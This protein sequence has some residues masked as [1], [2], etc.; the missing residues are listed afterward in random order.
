VTDAGIAARLRVRLS[1]GL[2][3]TLVL[4]GLYLALMAPRFLDHGGWAAITLP[5]TA[6]TRVAPM[7]PYDQ[8]MGGVALQKENLPTM[9]GVAMLE[10]GSVPAQFDLARLTY[11]YLASLLAPF[12]GLFHAFEIIN[13]ICWAAASL[14]SWRFARAITGSEAAGTLAAMLTVT[15]MGWAVHVSDYAAHI[16]AQVTYF[17]GMVALYESG[18][19]ERRRRLSVHLAL[20]AYMAIAS[21][22][23]NT[24]IMLAA[25]YAVLAFRRNRWTHMLIA[26]A[27]V[28]T[29]QPIWVR[30]M[31]LLATKS[32]ATWETKLLQTSAGYWVDALVQSPL[33]FAG[34]IAQDLIDF[35]TIDFPLILPLG[36]IGIA[37]APQLKGRRWFLLVATLVPIAAVMPFRMRVVGTIGYSIFGITPILHATI[38]ATIVAMAKGKARW[39]AVAAGVALVAAQA[40]WSTA[41]LWGWHAPLHAYFFGPFDMGGAWAT[42]VHAVSMT[43]GEPT[44]ALMGG[45]ASLTEAGLGSLPVPYISTSLNPFVALLAKALPTAYFLGLLMLLVPAGRARRCSLWGLLGLVVA[46]SLLVP[47]TNPLPPP[48]DVDYWSTFR[49][50]PGEPLRY[51]ARLSPAFVAGLSALP[52]DAAITLYLGIAGG[53][54]RVDFSAGGRAVPLPPMQAPSEWGQLIAIDRA[55]LLDRLASDPTIEVTI[56]PLQLVTFR[57]WQRGDLTNRSIVPAGPVLPIVELRGTAADGTLL[58]AGF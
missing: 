57:G 23:Y 15:G 52:R 16:L 20:A 56:T 26:L 55:D 5:T 39:V 24:G 29:A 48:L 35:A 54:S 36:L 46:S 21:L 45:S 44:P 12:F 30:I 43:G 9:K 10:G 27:I 7:I 41:W 8:I 28:V 18:V 58:L 2:V 50:S 38:A 19:W 49:Q 22:T 17:G 31:D 34:T 3:G 6:D 40:F 51:T 1:P 32:A 37:V 13:L 14:L 42:R 11:N 4:C 25:A 53:D 33:A 47:I